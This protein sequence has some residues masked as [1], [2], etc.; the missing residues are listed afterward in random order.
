MSGK[1]KTERFLLVRREI[2]GLSFNS[3]TG[4]HMYSP[5]NRKIFSQLVQAQISQKPKRF[6]SIFIAFFKFTKIF[7][8]FERKDK[9]HSLNISEVID[10][11]ERGFLNAR[12]LLLQYRLL[13]STS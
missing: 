8:R 1:S 3:L 12:K 4:D 9:L 11:E 6:S 5:F 13:K 10:T 7:E 2:L